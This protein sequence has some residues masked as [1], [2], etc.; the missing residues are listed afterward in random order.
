[1]SAEFD[2]KMN[3]KRMFRFLM[4][5]TYHGF[6]GLFGIVF[7]IAM[8]ALGAVTLRDGGSYAG[9]LY[10]FFAFY[11]LL[12][13]P[14]LLYLSA[15]KQ[16]KL[17]PVYK[18]PITYIVDDGGITS[19]QNEQEAHIGWEQVVKAVSAGGN[20]LIYTGK[21]R[22][23]VFPK[24]CMGEQAAAVEECIRKHLKPKQVKL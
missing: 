8:L 11:F 13:Q 20:L 22:S 10:L 17:N 16:V 5:H 21:N 14:V 9:M 3:R 19:R 23:A 24:E 4:Y 6:S 2:V 15:A 18:E 7:G 12:L 1:M